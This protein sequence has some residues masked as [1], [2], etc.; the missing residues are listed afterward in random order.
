[1]GFGCRF[2]LVRVWLVR[3]CGF[4]GLFWNFGG[5]LVGLDCLLMLFFLICLLMRWLGWMAWLMIVGLGWRI[6][7]PCGVDEVSV[8]RYFRWTFFGR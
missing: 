6:L 7:Q 3:V 2:S 4:E 5:E 1:M 8:V